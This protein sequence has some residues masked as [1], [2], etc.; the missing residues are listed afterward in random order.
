M[1]RR[2]SIT[3][4]MFLLFNLVLINQVYS[5]SVDKRK[6]NIVFFLVDDLGWADIQPNGSTFYET[7]NINKLANEGMRFTNAYAACPVCSPTRASITTGKYPVTMQTTDWFGADQSEEEEAKKK[8]YNR[9]LLPAPYKEYLPLE[10]QTLAEALKENGYKKVA[11]GKWHLGADTKPYQPNQRGFDKFYGFLGGSRR[12]FCNAA[13]EDKIG[14][15]QAILHNNQN[16]K[17]DGYL[18]DVFGD[19]VVGYIDKY[20]KEPFLMY[21]AFSA[22]H[23]PLDAKTKDLEKFKGHPRQKLAAINTSIITTSITFYTYQ[24]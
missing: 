3:K 5:Q 11:I 13:G 20:K 17:F 9:I 22:V 16:V 23:S 10:E 12:Y 14:N 7:P 15:D 19:Q 24:T 2:S 21:L 18:T 6:P 1:C 8:N 4:C